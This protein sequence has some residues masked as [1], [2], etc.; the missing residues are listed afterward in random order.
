MRSII[1]IKRQHSYFFFQW[2]IS[3]NLF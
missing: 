2:L 1:Q 3:V